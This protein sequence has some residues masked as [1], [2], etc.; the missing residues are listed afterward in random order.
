M[1]KVIRNPL[2]VIDAMILDDI[3]SISFYWRAPETGALLRAAAES[4]ILLRKEI[5]KELR[6][7]KQPKKW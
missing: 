4:L 7:K 3:G 1:E 5:L 2:D 6:A